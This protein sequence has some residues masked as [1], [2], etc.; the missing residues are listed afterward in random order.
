MPNP[1]NT[2]ARLEPHAWVDQVAGSWVTGSERLRDAFPD[3]FGRVDFDDD[4]SATYATVYV[5]RSEPAPNGIRYVLHVEAAPDVVNVVREWPSTPEELAS[6]MLAAFPQQP[7][8]DHAAAVS[9]EIHDL[10]SL[11]VETVRRARGEEFDK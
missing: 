8:D 3:D 6:L 1:Y 5:E 4:E 2:G 10:H 7:V 9:I 11:L